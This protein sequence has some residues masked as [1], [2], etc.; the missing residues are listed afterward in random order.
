M[1]V[2]LICLC[3]SLVSNLAKVEIK[4]SIQTSPFANF[5]FLTSNE[6]Q[7]KQK[8]MLLVLDE[9]QAHVKHDSCLRSSY[10]KKIVQGSYC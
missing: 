5:Y 1:T 2:V 10:M 7:R 6:L 4:Q 9:T 3:F 8:K